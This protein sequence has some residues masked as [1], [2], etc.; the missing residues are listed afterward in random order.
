MTN[1]NEPKIVLLIG[2]FPLRVF[3][4]CSLSR[5]PLS[6]FKI[7]AWALIRYLLATTKMTNQSE[8]TMITMPARII[9][10]TLTLQYI[11]RLEIPGVD[12]LGGALMSKLDDGM[13]G[14]S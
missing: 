5:T 3:A 12:T 4:V 14:N 6:Y 9:L 2:S 13:V 8:S 11:S 7:A 1:P 10:K